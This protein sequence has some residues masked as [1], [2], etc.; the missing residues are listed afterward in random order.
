MSRRRRDAA[1][2]AAR[3]QAEKWD[4]NAPPGPAHARGR[5]DVTEGTWMN[6]DVSPDGR[7]IA[8]DMLGDIYTMVGIEGGTPRRL[9]SGLAFDMQPRFSPDGRRS[10]SPPIA[11]AATISG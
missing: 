1:V 11:A 5:I 2:P 10:P 7:T 6:L 4:V 3:R 9:A 8:F